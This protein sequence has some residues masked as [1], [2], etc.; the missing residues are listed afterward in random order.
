MNISKPHTHTALVLFQNAIIIIVSLTT[1]GYFCIPRSLF[2]PTFSCHISHT[3]PYFPF[4]PHKFTPPCPVSPWEHSCLR[5]DSA[6]LSSSL[7]ISLDPVMDHS[8]S[9]GVI[10]TSCCQVRSVKNYPA[11]KPY[12]SMWLAKK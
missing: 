6:L 8:D 11:E 1:S 10:A 3:P 5:R 2:V 9:L 7:I 4:L 12:V